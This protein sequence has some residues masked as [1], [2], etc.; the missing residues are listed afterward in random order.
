MRYLD[1]YACALFFLIRMQDV[2]PETITWR[3]VLDTNDRFLRG[4]TIGQGPQEKGMERRTAFD[5]S[6][7]SETMAVLALSTSLSDMRERLG[8]MVVAT[9]RKGDPVN[10]DDLGVGGALTVLMKDAIQPTLM[11]TLEGTPV[12]VHAGPFANIAHGNSSVIADQLALKLVGKD[13]YVVTEAGFGADIGGE[14]F[15]NIKCRASKLQPSCFVLVATVRALKMHGGGPPVSAGKPLDETYKTENI[16]LVKAGCCNLAQH[17]QNITQFGIPCVVAI[18]RFASDSDLELNAVREAA[19]TAGATDAVVCRH[20]AVGGAGAVDLAEAVESACKRGGRL[21][22]TYTLD[23]PLREKLAA[24]AMNVYGASEDKPIELSN[25]AE[26]A[27]AR[28]E[29]MG[30]DR[31]PVCIAK[32]QYSFSDDPKAKGAPKGHTLHVREVRASVGAGFIV[33]ICGDMMMIPGLPTR[34][35]FYNIDI[36]PATGKVLG[37]M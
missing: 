30:F 26:N 13:G 17:V 21:K 24:V 12:F 28:Y 2:D 5:I 16:E 19:L 15:V 37:L 7:A 3:R 23:M 32:T 31:L 14:K 18:N 33:A 11:Q 25:D 1:L 4:I 36:D 27:I 34:P 20:H 9:S 22:F 35:A 6:V 29:A 8:R 10:A